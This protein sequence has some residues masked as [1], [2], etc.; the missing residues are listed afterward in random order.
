MTASIRS[1]SLSCIGSALVLLAAAPARAG[2]DA[3]S[4]TADRRV[5]VRVAEKLAAEALVVAEV[6]GSLPPG[7]YTIKRDDGGEPSPAEVFTLNGTTLL[8]FVP[9]R[10]VAGAPG[11]ILSRRQAKDQGLAIARDRLDAKRV[12]IATGGRPFT[13]YITAEGTK[14]YYFPVIGPTGASYTRAFPMEAVDG[15]DKDHPH[16]RSL[17]FTHGNVNGLDFWASDPNNKPNPKSGSIK[18]TSRTIVHNGERAAVLLTTDDWLGPDGKKICEDERIVG[19]FG[20]GKNRV[21]DFDITVKATAGPVT[22]G[23]TKEGMFGL[24]VASSMDVKNKDNSGGKITNAEGLT[25]EAAWGKASPW[26]DYVGPL[27][28]KT[29]GIAILNHPDSFR[30]PTTWHVRP[31]GLFAANPFGWH[32]F[33]QKTSGEYVIPAGES[34]RFMYR[35]VLH[36]GDTATSNLPGAFQAYAQPPLVEVK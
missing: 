17:W 11:Y 31:Y 36:T 6:K 16:Q 23:D 32:D 30:F 7:V 4:S 10:D 21:I 8:A 12:A 33:G 20:M 13:S 26:V 9:D 27:Q 25:D 22:F 28:G 5:V 19:F 34:I 15:E 14:P 24:R 3:G 18:E 2:D 35:V 1:L 29:A